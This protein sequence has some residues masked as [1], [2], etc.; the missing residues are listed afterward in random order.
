MNENAIE[1]TFFLGS[2]YNR[3]NVN[4]VFENLVSQKFYEINQAV[5]K[6]GQNR[7]SFNFFTMGDNNA[8]I[9][10]AAPVFTLSYI[11]SI[12]GPTFVFSYDAL[13]VVR[14]QVNYASPVIFI[15]RDNSDFMS[16]RPGV[17]HTFDMCD[18]I[19]FPNKYIKNI[20]ESKHGNT[21]GRS[22]IALPQS[23]EDYIGIIKYGKE[24]QEDIS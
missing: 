20:F 16:R 13:N 2:L 24:K 5:F 14:S 10:P 12:V 1:E 6:F 18:L 21:F 8:I 17:K 3:A 4:F 11:S 9:T 22:I 19:V 7:F 23:A 15:A